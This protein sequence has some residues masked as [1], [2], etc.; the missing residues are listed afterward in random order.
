VRLKSNETHQLLVCADG[1]DLLGCNIND[2]KKNTDT[3][4]DASK[5]A[6]L[7]VNAGQTKYIFLSRH[8]NPGQNRDIKK[9]NGSFENLAQ[10][11]CLG[12][13]VTNE[14]FI[15]EEINRRLNSGNVCYHSVQNFLSSH[16]LSKNLKI[17]IHNSLI[18]LSFCMGV[19]LGLC[20]YRRF[21][22]VVYLRT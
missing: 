13:T 17:V 4:N 3:L 15:Q 7:K 16:L 5:V 14:N 22:D 1:L 20:N 6:G 18:C 12:M 19:K 9:I 10:F 21:T 8:K 11:K 2:V